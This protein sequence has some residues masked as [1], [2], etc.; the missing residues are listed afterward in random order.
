MK[1]R[2]SYYDVILVFVLAGMFACSLAG[3]IVGATPGIVIGC[4]IS[5]FFWWLAIS[6]DCPSVKSP[7][8]AGG[9]GKTDTMPLEK[10]ENTNPQP[11]NRSRN[12]AEKA[13]GYYIW[14][15]V[16]FAAE[17][18]MISVF[19]CKRLYSSERLLGGLIVLAITIIIFLAPV[20]MFLFHFISRLKGKRG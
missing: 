3:V 20:I 11:G 7:A 14:T 2:L 6:D 10:Q 13:T 19:T 9:E 5:A 12:T 16:A 17:V 1:N 8:S 4:M 15:G 18:V